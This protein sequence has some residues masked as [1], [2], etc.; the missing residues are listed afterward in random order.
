MPTDGDQFTRADAQLI[1]EAHDIDNL[2]NDEEEC[3]LLEENNPAL[4]SAYQA[5]HS[6]ANG[7]S[8]E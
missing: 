8:D 2:L 5:L 3:D 6:F 4:L 1:C 7:G